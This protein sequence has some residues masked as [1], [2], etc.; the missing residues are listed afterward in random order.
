MKKEVIKPPLLVSEV[1]AVET[2]PS[3]LG[4]YDLTATYLMIVFYITNATTAVT[5]GVSA[6]TYWL[7]GGITFFLPSVIVTAQLGVMLPYEGS[8]YNWTHKA[9]GGFWS[10]F[11]AFC[12]WFPA[13][14]VMISAGDVIVSFLQGLNKDWLTSPIQQGA[15]IAV[16]LLFSGMI[17]TQRFRVVQNIINVVIVLTFC[18]VALIGLASISWLIQGH[19]S[20]TSFSHLADWSINW[21]PGTGNVNVFGLVTLAY[22]G[23]E[24]PLNMAGELKDRQAIRK[25][26]VWGTILVFAGYFIA[27]FALL[28]VMGPEQASATPFSLI[29]TVDK[30]LGKVAGNIAA[31]CL[32]SFFLMSIAVYSYTYSRLPFVAAI[33]Q[34]LPAFMGKLNKHRIPSRAIWL[35]TIFAVVVT[36]LVFIG[37]PLIA[38]TAD[39]T[40]IVYNVLL[41]SSTLVWAFS[42][43][44]L[45][46]D[47]AIF[48]FRDKAGFRHHQIFPLPLLGICCV[49]GS[50]SC[51]LAII[52]SLFYSWIVNLL[53]NLHWL[54]AIG[55]VTFVCII[56]ATIGSMLASSEAL[57]EGMINR[58]TKV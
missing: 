12:A 16:V 41:A 51:I 30:G 54:Y 21:Q 52:D 23:V 43:L 32:M 39:T 2:M 20:A 40:T 28:A 47:V 31:I 27:T 18:A 34:R 56:I 1:Y 46:V 42:T 6:F 22:L 9:F 48:Y 5:G 11:S 7:L 44:F 8:L 25:H 10:F 33:D 26:L 13:I 14:L 50:L 36:F 35:Q 17:A 49:L 19:A 53:D 3:I 4:T 58:E 29:S 45:F 57:W 24:G 15:V 55:G 38:N 37:V